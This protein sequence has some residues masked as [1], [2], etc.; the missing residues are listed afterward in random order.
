MVS[1]KKIFTNVKIL[2]L[3]FALILALVLI[4]P[5]F[6]DGVAIR[7]IQKDSVA[8]EADMVSPSASVKPMSREVILSVNNQEIKSVKEYHDAISLLIPDETFTVKTNRDTYY[9]TTRVSAENSSE[10]EDIGIT[11][12]P[13]P[14]TNIRKGLD[15]E[16]G[17]RVLLKP[18]EEITPEDL[19]LVITNIEQRLNVYGVS[20][21]TVRATKDLFGATFIAVEI[22][23]ANEQEVKNLLAQQ[24]KFEAKI[25]ND[26]VFRG[27]DQDILFVCK[28]STADCNAG[29]TPG[30]CTQITGG[31]YQCRFNFGITLSPEAAQRQA[32]LT[33][34]LSVMNL[35]TGIDNAYLTENLSLYLDDVLVDEL[36]I[37]ADL[38]GN[39]ITRISISGSGAGNNREEATTDALNNMKNLQTILETGSLPVKLNIVKT[40]SISPT[41]G[42]S[43]VRNASYAGIL[44]LIAV[45]T[46]IA[47]RYRRPIISIPIIITVLSEF[48]LTLGVA[49]L[50]GWRID[51]ASVAA[52]II[53]MGSGVNDQIVITDETLG[54]KGK[55][56]RREEQESWK[57]KL[58]RALF[59]IF[60]SYFTMLVAMLPLWFAGAGL[61]RG[62][63]LTTIIGITMGVLITRPA[64]GEFL[65]LFVENK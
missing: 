62:F 6:K 30:S 53:A 54:G 8:M 11:V 61:L 21:I 63:A 46:L 10:I 13:R 24:G 16:G 57:S 58:K 34:N 50:I 18:D 28:S 51:I 14:K 2:V 56:E 31:D 32:D 27:G 1:M 25:G 7:S 37:G 43:F 59:I 38:K 3:I 4:H 35:G 12:Y 41:L 65:D 29:I 48:T 15:L 47:V 36:L 9:L 5:S 39:A 40:D 49:A 42:S 60:A 19:D 22:P 45:V 64:F 26:T 23:G 17:T 33:R 44:A 52:L 20:D 55:K